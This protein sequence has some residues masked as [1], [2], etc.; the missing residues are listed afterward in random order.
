[1]IPLPSA[2]DP[3]TSLQRRTRILCVDDQPGFLWVL[4]SVLDHEADMQCVGCIESCDRLIEDIRASGAEVVLLDATMPGKDPVVAM[5]ELAV[6]LPQIKTIFYSGYDDQAF[7][8]RL[9]NAG[10]WGFVSKADETETIL[11]V[12][13]EVAMRPS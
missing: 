10:A 7:V 3:P 9:M 4:R 12:V 1:V 5:Q 13:R 2:S 11:S 6:E 8:D